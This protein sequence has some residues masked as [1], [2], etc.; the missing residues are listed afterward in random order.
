MSHSLNHP[1]GWPLYTP[2]SLLEPLP[3]PPPH[4]LSWWPP[5]SLTEKIEA[6][7][8]TS[9]SSHHCIHH[10]LSV[11]TSSACLPVLWTNCAPKGQP[12]LFASSAI[13]SQ[14]K[15]VTL[16]LPVSIN[17]SSLSASANMMQVLPSLISYLFLERRKRKE[18]EREW[19]INVWLPLT[20]PPL[21]TWP[22]P[23]HVYAPT[24]NWT[25]DPLVHRP[26]LNP[27]SHTSQ[28]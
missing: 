9:F 25:H 12:L 27:L 24:G 8:R 23:R 2:F 11:H 13:S 10:L 1:S 21:G 20:H 5:S 15:N 7:R 14:L 3:S 6:T 19:N 16:V 17:N 26:A 28:G 18:K 22:Q 4:S